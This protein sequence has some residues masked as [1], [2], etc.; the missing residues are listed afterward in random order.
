MELRISDMTHT[1]NTKNILDTN[2]LSFCT[3]TANAIILPGSGVFVY[4]M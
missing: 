4:F 2:Q 3:D 1:L